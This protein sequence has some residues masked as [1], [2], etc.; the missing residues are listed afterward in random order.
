V[1]PSE[2]TTRRPRFV[3]GWAHPCWWQSPPLAVGGSPRRASSPA[4]RAVGFS[5]ARLACGAPGYTLSSLDEGGWAGGRVTPPGA[6]LGR[7]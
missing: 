4:R 5:G 7:F 6:S 3:P 2:V 1:V